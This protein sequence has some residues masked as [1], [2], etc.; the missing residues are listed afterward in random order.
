MELEC[1]HV[2]DQVCHPA[3]LEHKERFACQQPCT[4][5]ICDLEHNCPRT[6]SEECGPCMVRVPKL[7]PVCN[8]EQGMPCSV[9]PAKFKCMELVPKHASPCGHVNQVQCCVASSD[10]VCKEQCGALECGHPCPG[11]CNRCQEGRLHLPCESK[12]SRTLFCGHTCKDNCVRTC[13][14]CSEPC[15]NY[16]DHQVCRRN[17][18]H[19]CATMCKLSAHAQCPHQ[20]CTK[21]CGEI[22]NRHEM[23]TNHARSSYR[24]A[25][26]V[27]GFV[28]KFA[29]S[30]VEFARR[31]SSERANLE[32]CSWNWLIVGH[33]FEVETL[34]RLMDEAD[35]RRWK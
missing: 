16:C 22:C 13:P 23:R 33:V 31:L 29:R 14:P 28:A 20:K 9:D 4:K 12:C 24:A 2:C 1:G 3:D 17:C 11:Y 27:L 15:S 7:I 6:C 19:P 8:H 10:I 25:T 5:S 21:P 18:G 34:D 26:R 32:Q 35:F 30:H